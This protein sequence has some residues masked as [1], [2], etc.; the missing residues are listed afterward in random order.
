MISPS[1]PG[2]GAASR[3]S[4]DVAA[5]VAAFEQSADFPA[6]IRTLQAIAGDADADSLVAAA[7]PYRDRAEIAGPLY[8]RVVDLRPDD[9]RALVAL[10]NAYWLHGRGGDVVGELASRAIAADPSL[11]G[12][13]HLWALSESDPRARV[14]RWQQVVDRF[15]DDDLARALLAD[16]AAS[17]AGAESDEHALALAI[18]TYEELLTRAGR[19]EQREALEKAITTL[20]S[21]SV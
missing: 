18:G 2:A 20:R 15:R 5:A 11:R 19:G 17:L 16:N 9:G 4:A 7:E 8:E 21:W 12:A 14:A 6:L 13:W 3:T 1:T 10:A